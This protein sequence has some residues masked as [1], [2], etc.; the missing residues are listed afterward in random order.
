MPI[1]AMETIELDSVTQE[2]HALEL[3]TLVVEDEYHVTV[4]D[5]DPAT[6]AVMGVVQ[7]ASKSQCKFHMP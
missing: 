3:I 2:K 6:W 5:T 1:V 4:P 7:S